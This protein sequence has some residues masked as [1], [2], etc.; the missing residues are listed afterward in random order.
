MIGLF[1]KHSIDQ[2]DY[3]VDFSKWLADSDT[4]TSADATVLPEGSLTIPSVS[5]SGQVV[6]VWTAGGVDGTSY[7]V[8]VAVGTSGGRVKEICF[9]IR[10]R[11]C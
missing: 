1:N 2:R 5:I 7:E 3:D 4:I 10:V 9:K 11:D 6:K 8:K